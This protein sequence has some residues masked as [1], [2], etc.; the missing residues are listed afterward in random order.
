[1][2]DYTARAGR[3]PDAAVRRDID[4]TGAAHACSP[5]QRRKDCGGGHPEQLRSGYRSPASGWSPPWA[6]AP[7][8][9]LENPACGRDRGAMLHR[10][11]MEGGDEKSTLRKS[12]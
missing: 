10:K 12:A 8:R 11:Q 2:R 9:E 7:E 5:P 3:H 4:I 1:M 6:L